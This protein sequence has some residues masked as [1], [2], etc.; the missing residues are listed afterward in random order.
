MILAV[1]GTLPFLAILWLLT[2]LGAMILEESG[3]K[4]AAALKGTQA[5][6]PVLV[7]PRVRVRARPQPLTRGAERARAAA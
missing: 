3:E 2:V 6:Q 5:H 4:I 7:T 1:L